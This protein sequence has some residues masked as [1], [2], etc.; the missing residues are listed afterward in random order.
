MRYVIA[1]ALALLGCSV[2]HASDQYSCNETTPCDNGR[3][4]DNGFCVLAGSIDAPRPMGDGPRGDVPNAGCPAGCTTCSV[5]QKTC[6]INCQFGGCNNTVTCPAGYKCDILCNTDS[7][8]R[9][10]V[11]CQLGTSCNVE[12][13]AKESCQNVVCGPGPCDVGCAGAASCKGVSCGNSCA[14]DVICT[15]NQACDG[16]QCSSLACGTTAGGCTSVPPL[17]HSCQ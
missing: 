16:I 9:N 4:C 5:Q 6:T 2:R 3:I 13:S 1:I 15:G 12:C 10:G 11:N 7:S 17:C 8:C 14:C